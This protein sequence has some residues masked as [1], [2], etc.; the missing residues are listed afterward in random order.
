MQSPEQPVLRDIVL[1]GGGHSHVG[2]LKRFGMKPLPGVRLTVICR[3]THTPYSGMLPGYIAGHYSY[4]EVHIDLNTL[5]AFAGARFYRADVIGLDRAAGKVLCQGRPPVPYDLLSINI[6]STPQ[7]SQVPGAAEHA[8][9]V[10]P[11]HLFNDRWLALLQRVRQHAGKTR[12]AIVGAGAGGVELTLAMQHRLRNELN[13]L[14]RD[15][16]ELSFHLFSDSASILPTHNSRVRSS[17]E[18]VLTARQVVTHIN[19]QV[20]QVS[21]R[22]LQTSDGTLLDMDEIVWVTQAGGAPWLQQTGLALDADGFIEVNDHLQSVNDPAVFAAGD[23]AT[24]VSRPLPKAGVFAVRQARPLAANLGRA[25]L[26]QALVRYRPQ[27]DWLALISTGDREAIASRGALGWSAQRALVWR[28]KDW[29]DRRFMDKFQTFPV[30]DET[31]SGKAKAP[32]IKLDQEEAAQAISAIAMRCGGCGAKVGATVLSRALGALQPIERDDVL[33]GLHA[34]D[35]AAI[36]RVPPGKAMVHTVDFFRAFIDDPY[37][38]GKVAANH[39]LGDIFAMGGQAQSATAIATVPAGLEAKVEDVL[40]QMMTGAV[41]VL[42]EAGCAL[43]GGHTGEGRELALGFA[44]N[45]L[46]DED[47]HTVMK[48]GGMR[49]GDVLLL[50]KPIGTGTLFAAH[51]RLQTRGRWIDAALASMIQ[52]NRLGAQCLQNHGATACTD[53]TGFG[54]LGHLVEMTRPSGVDAELYLS[55]LPLLDGARETAAAGILSS[56]QPANVRLRRALRNQAEAISH[57]NYPLIFDPQTAGGLLATVPADRAEACIAAL[58]GL[59]YDKTV[60][61]GRVLAQGDALEPI[62]LTC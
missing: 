53:L 62:V 15:P 40:F 5:A 27:R 34:P 59:G 29:I 33:I 48:K 38:F 30:M 7:M 54:L 41:E 60:A 47:L 49:P 19:S 52:S 2:V 56:L 24:L 25:V 26:G 22:G 3:D 21:A 1:V 28:W 58:R 23:I 46:V 32:G 17:F 9:A 43:V 35:D 31:A 16:N 20:T 10:K 55:A 51:A 45:G 11:I 42:N 12:I 8:V 18:R 50:T 37:L 14:G 44:I 13:T 6:G 57:P 36:V 4:D 39:A 61:I